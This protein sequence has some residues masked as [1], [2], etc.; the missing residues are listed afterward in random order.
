MSKYTTKFRAELPAAIAN[1]EPPQP[2]S[3]SQGEAVTRAR[4]VQAPLY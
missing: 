3:P 2:G 4:P 1:P